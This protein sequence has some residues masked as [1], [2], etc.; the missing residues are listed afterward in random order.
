M[1][2]TW[3][4]K[5]EQY[6][7]KDDVSSSADTI[8]P[9]PQFPDDERLNSDEWRQ[10][11]QFQSFWRVSKYFPHFLTSRLSW[12]AGVPF[13]CAMD[14]DL[15]VDSSALFRSSILVLMSSL[16]NTDTSP[17]AVTAKHL[18]KYRQEAQK[19]IK[20]GS[21]AE[22]TYCSYVVA[23]SSII[24]GESLQ[25]AMRYCRQFCKSFVELTK[26]RNHTD[27]WIEMLWR[28]SL[29]SLDYVHRDIVLYDCMRN[30]APSMEF[31]LLWEELLDA[32]SCLL[33]SEDDIANLPI[34]MSTKTEQI[35]H[36]IKSLSVYMHLSLDQ[37]LFR[38]KFAEN[39]EEM[40]LARSRLY[41]VLDRILRLMAYLPSIS[42]YI[43]RAYKTEPCAGPIDDATTS[44]FLQF[45][46]VHPCGLDVLP[47]TRDTGLALLYAF[48]RLL[49]NLLEPT[50]DVEEEIC[51]SATAIC[52][53]CANIPIG[54]VTET[55]IVK[56]SL[57]WAGLILTETRSPPGQS[58][59]YFSD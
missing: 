51:R 11:Q 24:R 52:R 8:L 2:K 16:K 59:L 34:S 7:L 56:R 36:K 57:F 32:S 26:K 14:S 25:M 40:E 47:I 21:L 29:M 38:A 5:R 39:T 1:P 20:A 12:Y 53:L 13:F 17:V 18:V 15:N 43:Y 42:D 6:Q 3:G 4:P 9:A 30:I 45:A 41:S 19:C 50:T 58:L 33:V 54:S 22:L 49:K 28:D 10:V 37:F 55:L 44:T 31:V 46:E 35:C 23:I 27:E 48:S